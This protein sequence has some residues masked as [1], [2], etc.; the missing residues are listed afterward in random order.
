M[1]K[2]YKHRL[3]E[4][5]VVSTSVK[6]MSQFSNNKYNISLRADMKKPQNST[7]PLLYSPSLNPTKHKYIKQKDRVTFFR[8]YV[9]C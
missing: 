9:S 1:A 3:G 5:N 4:K 8:S 7:V 2:S 6:C